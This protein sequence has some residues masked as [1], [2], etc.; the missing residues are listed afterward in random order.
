[1][2]YNTST[3]KLNYYEPL[4]K[5]GKPSK[6][7]PPTYMDGVEIQK[8]HALAEKLAC[9]MERTALT[10]AGNGVSVGTY[11]TVIDYFDDCACFVGYDV[12][13]EEKHWYIPVVSD[14]TIQEFTDFI[15]TQVSDRIAWQVGIRSVK[16]RVRIGIYAQMY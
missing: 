9:I 13:P 1:M 5:A 2:D 8:I 12:V 14:D 16:G 15:N 10:F 3:Q 4:I 11:H 7:P 6:H